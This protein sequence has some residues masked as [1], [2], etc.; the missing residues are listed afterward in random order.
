MKGSRTIRLIAKRELVT[1]KRAFSIST[2]II[3]SLVVAGFVALELSGVAE[4]V[5]I[6]E[7]RADRV[8]AMFG[9]IVLFGTI[10][11]YG[12]MTLLGVAEEK[13]SRVVEVVLGAVEPTRLLAGKIIGIGIFALAQTGIVLATIAGLL[14]TM[15]TLPLPAGAGMNLLNVF[16]FFLLGFAFYSTVYAAFGALMARTENASNAAGPLNLVVSI[17]YVASIIS[18]QAGDNLFA[19]ILSFLPPFTPIVMPMRIVSGRPAMWE[20]ALAVVLLCAAIYG[21]TRFAARIYIGGVMRGGA[22]SGLREAWRTAT[23]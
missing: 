1:R 16:V 17:G 6:P 8:M 7:D 10:V 14:F 15:D 22:K 20:I 13:S 18:V 9:T 12:Q 4:G 2:G 11:G 23:L 3:W 19:R 5:Y 21:V